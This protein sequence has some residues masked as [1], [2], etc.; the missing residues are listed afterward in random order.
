MEQRHIV[1]RKVFNEEIRKKW[2]EM[3]F[4]SFVEKPVG[5][6]QWY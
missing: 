2:Q 6:T 3:A 4:K 5:L 1:T